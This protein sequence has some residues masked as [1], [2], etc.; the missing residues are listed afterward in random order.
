MGPSCEV[1]PEIT[2]HVPFVPATL[3]I[4]KTAEVHKTAAMIILPA[5]L[6]PDIDTAQDVQTVVLVIV[7]LPTI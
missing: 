4:V 7:A 1:V 5:V 3:L 6:P 2:L